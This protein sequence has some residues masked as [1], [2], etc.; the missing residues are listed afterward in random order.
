MNSTEKALSYFL[1]SYNCAQ[2]VIMAYAGEFGIEE[3]QA[4]K[5]AAGFG[6]GC[7]RLQ[8]MCGALSGGVMV[9]G[10]RFYDP[11]DKVV[12]KDITYQ[13]TREFITE[14]TKKNGHSD[15]IHL[16]GVDTSTPEGA[17]KA[18]DMNLSRIKCDGYINDVCR[19]LDETIAR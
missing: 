4:A 12:S 11:N 2:S 10:C 3:V 1:D 5:L 19:M 6:G 17:Q 15:C 16:L 14:F 7:G 9:L 8:K 13:R 18:K